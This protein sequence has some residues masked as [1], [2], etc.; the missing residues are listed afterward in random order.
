MKSLI[1]SVIVFF[2]F[3]PGILF[4]Q[5]TI[6]GWNFP[7]NPDDEFVD[8]FVSVN[9]GTI[10]SSQGGT[11]AVVFNNTGATTNCALANGWDSGSGVKYWEINIASTGFVNLAISSKQRSS[12]T[13]PREFKIQYK[14]GAGAWTD[15]P[16]ALNIVVAD[17]FTTGV[18]NAVSVPAVCE[19]QPSISFRWIMRS[20]TSVGGGTVGSAGTSRID[21]IVITGFSDDYYRSVASGNWNAT[22]TW[23]SSPDN[24]VWNPA[25]MP[26]SN[27]SKTIT[28]RNPHIVT[29]NSNVNLDETVVQNGATLNW[30]GANLTIFNGTGIDLQ[31]D[32]T[33]IDNSTNN[34]T[35]NVGATWTLGA[36]A[37]Y[38]KTN[39]GSAN[40]WRDNYN[41]GISTIPSTA[42]WII[43]KVSANNPSVSTVNMYYPNLIIENNTAGNWV[44]SGSSGF[45]G[46]TTNTIIKGYMDVGGT[47]SGTVEFINSNTNASS[48]V[49]TGN[50]TIRTGNTL[51][52]Y[53]TGYELFS[54]LI[55]DGS[56]TYDANDARRL[57]FS[58]GVM[59]VITGSG[60]LNVWNMI[61]NKT[62]GDLTLLRSVKVDNNITFNNPGGRIFSTSANLLIIESN[63]TA[64]GANNSSFVHGPVQK[65][66][67]AA[68]TFPVGKIND[69]QSIGMGTGGG[70]GGGIF[71]TEDFGTGCT[72]GLLASSYTGPNGSWGITST[73]TNNAQSN[74]W[75]ISA[76]E[77]GMGSGNCGDGCLG[78]GSLTNR[79][80]HVGANDGFT[81]TDPGAA[82][83]AGGL[84]GFWF[85]V[86]TNWR[87]ES[88]VIN[89][90]GQSGITLTFQYMEN[91]MGT[92]DNATLWYFNGA[93]WSQIVDL[94]KTTAC[95]SGQGLWTSYS[96]SLP[97]SADNNPNVRIG[98]NWTNNDDGSGS[99]PSFAVDN[100][101]LSTPLS[102][103]SYTAEYFR[104]NPQVIFNNNVNAPLDH[105]SQCEYWILNR[106]AGTSSRNVTLVWDNNSC[107]VT[108]LADLRVARF[109]SVSW[110]DRGNGGT[111]G[112]TAAG[113]ITSAMPQT[114]YGPFTLASVTPQNPL[115][116]ELILLDAKFV[117]PGVLVSWTTASETDNDYFLVQRSVHSTFETVGTVNGSGNSNSVL[118]YSFL[119]K[120]P[121][122]GRN[123]Y[124]L[125]QVDY[126]GKFEITP[127]VS[128]W[129]PSEQVSSFLNV[130]YTSADNSLLA[131]L[132]CPDNRE[133]NLEIADVTGRIIRSF[134][135]TGQ[136]VATPVS[137]PLDG[138]VNGIYFLRASWDE[139]VMNTRFL[140]Y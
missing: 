133:V 102:T 41:T 123:Y 98:F 40:N 24:V 34:V 79:T 94:P 56:V 60:S 93:V 89:C 88:P 6:A 67:N 132:C 61:M 38:I 22:S 90:T 2:S 28:I 23:E 53:G 59:Q 71:W 126:D 119:D 13:G 84:C 137:L 115:P 91:G 121:L 117:N 42:N 58:G 83:N 125:K 131:S 105:I 31:V 48:T 111:T 39:N 129:V 130:Y 18:V 82:Y 127:V 52:N 106:D 101:Q 47:G 81:P 45:Q 16:G 76:T 72:Q 21:D 110:D 97:A 15:L 109:N 100:I 95:G 50:L 57:T 136:K 62:T 35:F 11:G 103:E 85:C 135:I 54:N 138:L 14:V 64:T 86:T 3:L 29:I 140:R 4:A 80:L 12:S 51:S 37:T 30:S 8:V 68:F 78:N 124:R 104:G 46:N 26:P 5:Q 107:G 9:S 113:T 44:A 25:I 75:Y 19:N 20:N 49:V 63:A 112:T 128:A 74:K 96:I 69:Y 120:H 7:N 122:P 65:L 43:R 108:N 36:S 33:F 66:G 1:F 32:G 55:C 77:A 139:T 114:D 17:N 116:V 92:S 118:N 27:Y 73:G 134:S 10:I 87:A 70:G 99:D